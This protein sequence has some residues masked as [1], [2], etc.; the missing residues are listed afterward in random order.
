MKIIKI[1]QQAFYSIRYINAGKRGGIVKEILPFFKAYSP[2]LPDELDAILITSDLQG[3][4]THGTAYQLL[5]VAVAQAY[6]ELAQQGHIPSPK[7][8][9]VIL[10]GDLYAATDGAQRGASGDVTSVWQAFASFAWVAGVQGNH[11]RFVDLDWFASEPN[12]HLLDHD[13]MSLSGYQIAGVGG[14]IGDEQVAGYRG[15]ADFF[16]ALSLVL[17]QK[18]EILILH[19]GAQGHDQQRGH[20]EIRQQ[21]LAARQPLTICGHVHWEQPLAQLADDV[22]VLNVDRRVVVLQRASRSVA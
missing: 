2:T 10:A 6:R 14:V 5:G 20:P 9:G 12:I 16:A 22:Q 1:D 7:R 8:T 13:V 15:E 4:V 18:P 17:E 19:Q 11:D 3:V 21:I